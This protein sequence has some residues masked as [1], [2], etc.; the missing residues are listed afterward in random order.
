MEVCIVSTTKHLGVH[1]SEVFRSAWSETLTTVMGAVLAMVR[2]SSGFNLIAIASIL[3]AKV[4]FFNYNLKAVSCNVS[5]F[6]AF[7]TNVLGAVSIEVIFLVTSMAD[8]SLG[9][10]LRTVRCNMS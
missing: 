8:S 7:T 4:L 5:L 6:I 9:Y 10:L 2:E 1:A 3:I